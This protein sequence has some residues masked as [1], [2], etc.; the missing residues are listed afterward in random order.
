MDAIQGR[1]EF[2]VDSVDMICQPAN[3]QPAFKASTWACGT[4][5]A[6][7]F[8][9]DLLYDHLR[10]SADSFAVHL[11]NAPHIRLDLQ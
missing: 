7:D 5:G 9:V 4:Q 2:A 1:F 8:F 11:Q 10:R 6:F 3:A